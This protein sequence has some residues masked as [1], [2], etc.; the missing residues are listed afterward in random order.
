M[1]SVLARM[2]TALVKRIAYNNLVSEIEGL[3]LREADDI[4]LHRSNARQIAKD[5]IYR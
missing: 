3:S 5:A 2:Q 1:N 4:G